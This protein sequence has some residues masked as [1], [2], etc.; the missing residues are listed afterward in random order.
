[1]NNNNRHSTKKQLLLFMFLAIGIAIG[2]YFNQTAIGLNFSFNKSWQS[3][4]ILAF[5]ESA[6]YVSLAFLLG[7]CAVSWPLL[8]IVS[9]LKGLGLGAVAQSIYA[10][11]NIF[12]A[13]LL[14]LPFSG[15]SCF[16]LMSQTVNSI[17]MSVRYFA[18]SVTAE[19]RLGM[20]VEFK[21]YIF[22]YLVNLTLCGI[23]AALNSLAVLVCRY[24]GYI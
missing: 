5:C 22:K 24:F 13:I 18:I 8:H 10:S 2:A 21:E 14:F 3:V 6:L 19:N 15:M 17:F 1:M 9:L 7:F 16:V 12:P 11:G 20:A 4:L 23:I